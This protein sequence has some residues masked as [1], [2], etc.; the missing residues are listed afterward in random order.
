MRLLTRHLLFSRAL[1][2]YNNSA[3]HR[4]TAP[5]VYVMMVIYHYPGLSFT[6]L[7]DNLDLVLHSNNDIR[8]QNC[9]FDLQSWDYV[10]NTPGSG[11]HSYSLTPAGSAVLI[12]L[13]DKLRRER[14]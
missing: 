4:I 8:L 3:V 10:I 11:K 5:Y 6:Q 12:T 7:S 13:E 2:G 1:V 9:L 14:F